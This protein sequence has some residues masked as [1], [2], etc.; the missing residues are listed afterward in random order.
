MKFSILNKNAGL[1]VHIYHTD[2][3][4]KWIR[5]VYLANPS[6]KLEFQ[7]YITEKNDAIYEEDIHISEMN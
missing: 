4:G 3:S 6:G 2:E 5:D 1:A 7:S